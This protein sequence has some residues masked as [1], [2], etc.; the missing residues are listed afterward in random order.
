MLEELAG[1]AARH[2]PELGAILRACIERY[3]YDKIRQ[4]VDS[5]SDK[6]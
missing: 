3:D 4:L 1:E 5:G 6:P 2:N